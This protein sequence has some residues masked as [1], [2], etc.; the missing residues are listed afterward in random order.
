[1]FGE[2]MFLNN[3]K[4]MDGVYIWLFILGLV[5]GLGAAYATLRF[6]PGFAGLVG[7]V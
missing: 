2:E 6:I 4:G 1:L 5:V 3:K 7:I